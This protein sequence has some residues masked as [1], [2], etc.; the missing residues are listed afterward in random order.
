MKP[1][2]EK[3]SRYTA[4]QDAKQAGIYPYFRAISS[5]Q[6][7]EVIIDGRKVLMLGSNSYLGLTNHPKIK[8]AAK[9]AID[10]YGTGCAGSPFLNGTLDLHIE[11]E[12]KLAEFFNKGGVMLYSTGFQTNVGVIPCVTGRND[13]IIFDE[14]DHAS[15]IEG[16]RLSFANTL[17]FKH[18]DMNNLERVLQ[19]CPIESAKLIVVDGVFSMEGEIVKLPELVEIANKYNASVMVDEAHGLGV[20]GSKGRGTCD[21]FDVVDNVDIIM[22][23]FSKSL[24]SIGGFVAADAETINWMKHNSRSYIFSASISPAATA[25]AMAAFDIMVSEPWRQDNLWKVTNHALNGFRQLGFEIGNT[26]TPII[27]LFVRDNEKTFIVT[28]MLLDEGVFV[29]PV[30]SPAVAPDDTLIRISLM[31]T[32]TTEQI[33]YAIDKIYKCFKRLEILK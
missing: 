19:K 20:L 25:A 9:A 29:N 13:Y 4:P 17:K 31:A 6:D 11:F 2:Q 16:K 21:H 8:E 1:L 33:D 28:K 27:P 14:T 24:A 32:H 10:K 12:N 23:T 18:N 5:D 7:A 15:I 26:E 22:G 3:L 30:I